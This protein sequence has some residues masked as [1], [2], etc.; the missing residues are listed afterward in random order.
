[1]KKQLLNPIMLLFSL[2]LFLLIQVNFAQSAKPA[3][4]DCLACHSDKDLSKVFKGKTISLWVK[5]APFVSSVHGKLLCVDCHK[6]FNPDDIPHKANIKPPECTSCHKDVGSKHTFHPQM[7]YQ[8]PGSNKDLFDCKRCHGTHDITKPKQSLFTSAGNNS[9]EF[10]GKCHKDQKDQHLK[11]EHYKAYLNKNPNAPTCSSCHSKPITKYWIKDEIELREKQLQLCLSC[12]KDK[13]DGKSQ[14]LKTIDYQNSNHGKAHSKGFKEAATCIDCHGIH[15]IMKSD[16]AG[17]SIYKTRV[18]QLCRKCHMTITQEFL[19]T[20]H[21]IA[22]TQGNKD[23]P[24]CLTCHNEHYANKVPEYNAQNFKNSYLDPDILIK[25]KMI[26]CAVC[27]SNDE[28][29]KRNNL[30]AFD[31]AHSFLPNRDLYMKDVRCVECHSSNSSAGMPH[32]IL[33]QSKA[34][35]NCMECHKDDNWLLTRL[36]KHEK[37][38]A[39]REMGAIKGALFTDGGLTRATFNLLFDS[40]GVIAIGLILVSIIIH[41][42]LRW[43]FKRAGAKK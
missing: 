37:T 32:H 21:G 40:I 8:T 3:I 15:N 13:K 39:K 24:A 27:H 43:Y 33:P 17:S 16:S 2:S 41:S 26:Y 23:A 36:S 1:M 34:I 31:D 20:A 19:T 25:N 28:F 11:S 22:L 12:H 7:A 5:K 42:F 18:P 4:D 35:K 38:K 29:Q 14:T 9:I 6:D 30:K 10:C